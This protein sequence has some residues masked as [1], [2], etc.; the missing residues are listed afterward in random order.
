[1]EALA[2]ILQ[3]SIVSALQDKIT[4]FAKSLIGINQ[5]NF[6]KAFVAGVLSFSIPGSSKNN[7]DGND[8]PLG[9]I[10][11]VNDPLD[12]ALFAAGFSEKLSGVAAKVAVLK[13]LLE[14]AAEYIKIFSQYDLFGVRDSR[15]TIVG[16][17]GND[18]IKSDAFAFNTYIYNVGDGDDTI[19]GFNINDKLKIVGSAYT[20]VWSD[21]GNGSNLIFKISNGSITLLDARDKPEIL[22]VVGRYGEETEE[23]TVGGSGSSDPTSTPDSSPITYD[24]DNITPDENGKIVI[25]A[26]V[27]TDEMVIIDAD[28]Y[29]NAKEIDAKKRSG[30][31]VIIFNGTT[32][33]GGVEKIIGSDGSDTVYNFKANVLIESNNSGDYIYNSGDNVTINT[34][35]GNDTIVNDGNNVTIDG[36]TD[37]DLIVSQGENVSINGG[38]GQD[39]IQLGGDST[40]VTTVV[41]G[42]GNDAI[43]GNSAAN[44]YK[45]E[46]GDG[47]DT[48]YYYNAGSKLKLNVDYIED[49]V[50]EGSGDGV[51]Q[52][53]NEDRTSVGDSI[54]LK[55]VAGIRIE[56]ENVSGAGYYYYSGPTVSPAESNPPSGVTKDSNSLKIA[57]ADNST[58][59][60]TIDSSE[61]YVSNIS[62][63]DA[64]DNTNG[65]FIMGGQSSA[66]NSILGSK[67]DDTIFSYESNAN[68]DANQGYNIIHNVGGSSVTINAGK[69]GSV[70]ENVKGN[71]SFIRT[72]DGD[73]KVLNFES[74]EVT[75]EGYAGNDHIVSSGSKNVSIY[76][77]SGDNIISLEG[78]SNNTVKADS[79]NDTIFSN[80]GSNV[81]QYVDGDDVIFGYDSNNTIMLADDK[82]IENILVD[83]NNDVI[84]TMTYKN[85]TS[86]L[87]EGSLGTITLKNSGGKQILIG[88]SMANI[89]SH[90]TT[91]KNANIH[92]EIPNQVITAGTGNDTI[93]NEGSN[94]TINAG[95]GNDTIT[96]SG[97]EVI[98]KYADGDGN[99]T[100]T[101]FSATDTLQIIS[102]TYTAKADSSGNVNITVGNGTIKLVGMAGKDISIQNTD[103]SLTT[104]NSSSG[105]T[106]SSGGSSSSGGTS[107]TSTPIQKSGESYTYSG[108]NKTV[109][110]Y[111]SGE[112]IQ[113]A[114]N[115][116]GFNVSGNNLEINSSNGKLTIQNCK[117]KIV[118]ITDANGNTAAYAFVASGGGEIN[119]SGITQ[120][121]VIVGSSNADN[122]II[123]GDGG[124]SLIGGG[125]NNTLQGGAGADTF[126][127]NTGNDIISNYGAGDKINF[128]VQFTG[129]GINGSDFAIN[130]S[131]GS[132]IIQDAKDK[133]IEVADASGNV[134][135]RVYMA[136][137]SGVID[138]RGIGGIELIT[139]GNNVSNE[140]FAGDGGSSLWGGASGNDILTGGAGQDN[141]FYGKNDGA[142]VINNASSS[143]TVNLYD[144]TLADITAAVTSENQ[145]S[146]TF[147]TGSNLQINSAENLSA[148]F[149][150]AD[151]NWKFNHSSGTWQNAI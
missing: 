39:T 85:S 69:E 90:D 118:E 60:T 24:P 125:G 83:D 112:K 120:F 11:G 94:V 76:A 116:T 30:G 129:I 63:I 59:Q 21:N 6:A 127:F 13:I 56:V 33:N 96:N 68:I 133:V 87:A 109:A 36:G 15:S 66:F 134:A 1:M 50:V 147:N 14:T 113:I 26:Q 142:D 35:V 115:A 136:S 106:S 104:Y 22:T 54:T 34:G 111:T 119:G 135:A 5:N 65:V 95:V 58:T 2:K 67:G 70:T 31:S 72:G 46:I 44:V 91:A 42:A 49:F 45:Y 150:L 4:S 29:S 93:V 80:N 99:D 57:N 28:T 88:D 117:D 9:D 128:N 123:A 53:W 81:L 140:I 32:D 20:T 52:L 100:I 12:A 103:G 3:S 148:T 144:V 61:G 19:D 77:G 41:G 18:S 139:G 79:G 73:N 7:S 74:D 138:G 23:K 47:N 97:S 78:G 89:T 114:N 122:Y 92:N 145:I 16:G 75:V 27:T 64:S 143:D 55:D 105:G 84:L 51:L 40:A 62:T 107:S 101:G 137:N 131:T 48:I 71:K 126:V 151:G 130:S 132:V 121:E 141:F 98:F 17:L 43:Y 110:N 8:L 146:V 124:S 38:A 149:N 10:L 102:G 108:G 86:D 37:G 25:D 82:Q